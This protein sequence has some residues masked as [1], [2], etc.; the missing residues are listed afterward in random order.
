MKR[1]SLIL[2]AV[3]VGMCLSMTACHRDKLPPEESLPISSNDESENTSSDHVSDETSLQESESKSRESEDTSPNSSSKPSKSSHVESASGKSSSETTS[4]ENT[5]QPKSS[6]QNSSEEST[7]KPDPSGS[8]SSQSSSDT[9]SK[10]SSSESASSQSS[11]EP[12]SEESSSAPESSQPSSSEES[13]SE[14]EE[15]ETSCSDILAEATSGVTLPQMAFYR[16]SGTAKQKDALIKKYYTELNLQD[17]ADFAIAVSLLNVDASEVAI[18]RPASRDAA[19]QIKAAIDAR[20]AVLEEV[21]SRYLPDQYELVENHQIVEKNGY[22]LFVISKD[23]D[24]IAEQF[25]KSCGAEH[26]HP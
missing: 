7:S 12:S 1:V 19:Q 10:S 8:T 25:R 22:I 11:S 24:T 17:A 18:F 21:W 15:K 16:A 20:L 13:S 4:E 2:V 14:P 9:T 5:S 3:L 6:K 26:A 23:A